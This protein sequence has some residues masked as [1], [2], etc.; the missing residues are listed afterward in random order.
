MRFERS[1][2]G[3]EHFMNYQFYLPLIIILVVATSCSQN[4]YVSSTEYDDLYVNSWDIEDFK[5][6]QLARKK[7][8]A[9]LQKERAEEYEVKVEP[10]VLIHKEGEDQNRSSS[11]FDP[12]WDRPQRNS[13]NYNSPYLSPSMSLGY[14]YPN[15]YGWGSYN[16][17]PNTYNNYP[18]YSGGY[19]N[20]PWY[21]G[22]YYHNYP[23]QYDPYYPN[24]FYNSGYYNGYNNGF[25]NGYYSGGNNNSGYSG[26]NYNNGYT[27]GSNSNNTKGKPTNK[28]RTSVGSTTNTNTNTNSGSSG[29]NPQKTS[30][31][32]SNQNNNIYYAPT[33]SGSNNSG[34]GSNYNYRRNHNSTNSSGGNNYNNS[35]SGGG[36]NTSKPTPAPAPSGGRPA[37]KK[38]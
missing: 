2:N 19:Y 18:F 5:E 24:N 38:F 10:K 14:G 8:L 21:G 15:N 25:Y 30:P 26:G 1:Y 29:Q 23:Y 3:K 32:T 37:Y 6:E 20:D 31:S 27:G 36:S 35:N 9:E 17:Y 34:G 13:W 11:Y 22:N 4:S 28:P 7:E 33:P 12:F 16:Y